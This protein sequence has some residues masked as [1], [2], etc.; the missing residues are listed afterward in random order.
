MTDAGRMKGKWTLPYTIDLGVQNEA[1]QRLIEISQENV[2]VIAMTLFHKH[3]R[4]L[5]T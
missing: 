3:K 4:S 5:Q 1:G 2:L